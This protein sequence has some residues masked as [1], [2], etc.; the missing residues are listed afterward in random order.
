MVFPWLLGDFPTFPRH[1]PRLSR[2]AAAKPQGRQVGGQ[3]PG[4]RG[5]G[6]AG[7]Q[8]LV[9]GVLEEPPEV[10]FPLV[11]STVCELENHHRNSEFS[12]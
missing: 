6:V 9:E 11:M 4:L 5:R 12:H 8:G 10:T 1:S 2:S 3:L 7:D